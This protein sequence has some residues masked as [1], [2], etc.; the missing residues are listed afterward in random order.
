MSGEKIKYELVEDLRLFPGHG[1]SGV[2]HHGPFVAFHV[3]GPEPHHGRWRQ[4]IGIGGDD[5]RLIL[6]GERDGIYADLIFA[7]ADLVLNRLLKQQRRNLAA[8]T[9]SCHKLG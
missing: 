6:C 5:Q 1:V 7:F 2:L 3:R 9:L 8:S 4:E